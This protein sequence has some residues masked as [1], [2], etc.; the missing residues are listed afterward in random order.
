M[1]THAVLMAVAVTF[2]FS[3]T[4]LDSSTQKPAGNTCSAVIKKVD[5]DQKNVY[6]SVEGFKNEDDCWE[7]LEHWT[8]GALQH[9]G[10]K[11]FN[12]HY[13]DSLPDFKKPL[14]GFYGSTAIQ[15]RVIMQVTLNAAGEKMVFKSPFGVQKYIQKSDSITAEP[16]QAPMLVQSSWQYQTEVD[17]MTGKEIKFAYTYSTNTLNFDFPYQGGTTGQLLI[18]R[19]KGVTDVALQIDKGQFMSNLM[20]DEHLRVRFDDGPVN[21]WG[22]ANAADGSSNIVFPSNAQKFVKSVKKAKKLM[23]EA[24]YFNEGRQVLEFDIV[25]FEW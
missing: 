2:L 7:L 23:I 15:N 19:I 17:K 12:V 14:D 20:G 22:F 24:P 4:N 9:Y 8:D 3:C 10:K 5:Y 1:K 25:G 16:N 13:L 21:N 11:V 6:Y 18:R